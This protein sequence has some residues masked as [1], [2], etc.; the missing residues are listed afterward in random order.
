MLCYNTVCTPTLSNHA[1]LS[2]TVSSHALLQ[3][4]PYCTGYA[5]MDTG[6]AISLLVMHGVHCLSLLYPPLYHPVACTQHLLVS[7]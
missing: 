3:A 1:M 6:Y 5:M 2:Y 4:M 7:V